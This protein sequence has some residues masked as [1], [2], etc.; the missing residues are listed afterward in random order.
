[1][2]LRQGFVEN[3]I[4]FLGKHFSREFLVTVQ[5]KKAEMYESLQSGNFASQ[6]SVMV[7]PN[8]HTK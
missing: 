1:M 4:G 3:T 7:G 6:G 2:R 5:L 8:S